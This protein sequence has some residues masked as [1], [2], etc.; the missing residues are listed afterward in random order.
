M[1]ETNI[2]LSNIKSVK[3]IAIPSVV[4]TGKDFKNAKIAWIK[5]EDGRSLDI[6][7]DDH[8]NLLV[9]TGLLARIEYFY[10]K[11]FEPILFDNRPAYAHVYA[12]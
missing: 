9:D 5:T 6:I 2:K 10:G 1:N 3:I 8:G 12:A 7:F 11:A 4:I